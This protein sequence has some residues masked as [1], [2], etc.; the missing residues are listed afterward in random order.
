MSHLLVPSFIVGIAATTTALSG[1]GNKLIL[2]I[3]FPCTP[4]CILRRAVEKSATA[5]TSPNMLSFYDSSARRKDLHQGDIH[6]LAMPV[7]INLDARL[8]QKVHPTAE[9]SI[10]L[11]PA[12]RIVL[13]LGD[14][15]PPVVVVFVVLIVAMPDWDAR[16]ASCHT[17]K[18]YCNNQQQSGACEGC[19]RYS[20]CCPHR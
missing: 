2:G 4:P 1:W 5:P 16:S 12:I 19:W 20:S 11:T 13:R 10:A 8:V 14:R 6:L 15:R 7:W 3:L 9:A 17:W 18:C